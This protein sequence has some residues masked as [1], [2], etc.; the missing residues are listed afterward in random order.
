MFNRGIAKEGDLLDLGV[1]MEVVKKS[2]AF[3]S[4]GDLRLGQG[5]EAAKEYLR[6]HPEVQA[7]VEQRIR[8]A[9][10]VPID[11][12]IAPAEEAAETDEEIEET[13]Q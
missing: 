7:E 8:G 2:G 12:G 10:R 4:Y 9:A 13:E 6:Q 5:R 11:L 1:G 3:Y